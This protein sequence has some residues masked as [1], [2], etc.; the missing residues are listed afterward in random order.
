MKYPHVTLHWREVDATTG[1]AILARATDRM[2]WANGTLFSERK[3]ARSFDVLFQEID[4]RFFVPP[5]RGEKA[6]E[7]TP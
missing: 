4:G 7:S 1:N 3:L 5:V 2:Q 6:K